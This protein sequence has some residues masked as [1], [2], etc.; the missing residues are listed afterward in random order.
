MLQLETNELFDLV[1][2]ACSFLPSED[3]ASLYSLDYISW[4]QALLQ[5]HP[6]RTLPQDATLIARLYQQTPRAYTLQFLSFLYEDESVSTL[7]PLNLFNEQVFHAPLGQELSA[8]PEELLELFR[9]ALYGEVQ[10]GYLALRDAQLNAL[11][12]EAS[13]LFSEALSPLCQR[14]PGLRAVR[15]RLSH[16]LRGAGRLW[17]RPKQRLIAVGLPGSFGLEARQIVFQG[18]HEYFLAEVSRFAPELREVER[19]SFEDPAF[20]GAEITA[21]SVGALCW[22]GTTFDDLFDAF[23]YEVASPGELASGALVPAEWR[24]CF[25]RAQRLLL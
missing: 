24:D 19:A 6:L 20:Y 18:C 13:R 8:L 16:P 2:H 3:N 9:I 5:E 23:V 12:P 15:W 14:W 10:A 4:A 22:R 25:L 1:I 7:Q 17:Y 21:L 11:L